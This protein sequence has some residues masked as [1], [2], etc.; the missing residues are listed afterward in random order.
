MRYSSLTRCGMV[1]LSAAMVMSVF[2]QTARAQSPLWPLFHPHGSYTR[3]RSVGSIAPSSSVALVP[4]QGAQ[5]SAVGASGVSGLTLVP[6][7]T[8]RAV[9]VAATPTNQLVQAPTNTVSVASAGSTTSYYIVRGGGAQTNLVFVP[10][11]SQSSNSPNVAVAGSVEA[12]RALMSVGF[13]NSPSKITDLEQTLESQLGGMLGQNFN[14]NQLT[15]ML[16]GGAMQFLSDN[17]YAGLISDAEPIVARLIGRLLQKKG[18]PAP[19]P[20]PTTPTNPTTPTTP[21]IQPNPQPGSFQGNV[22]SGSQTF[23]ITVTVTPQSS[24]SAIQGQA[25]TSGPTPG[26]LPNNLPTLNNAQPAAPPAAN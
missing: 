10:V 9:G 12:D 3:T 25:P 5:T 20:A 1:I 16:M 26:T 23:T 6:I 22:T 18:I 8:G 2:G 7:S 21:R 24:T 4:L 14:G 11:S 15:S 17:S 19:P 13:S